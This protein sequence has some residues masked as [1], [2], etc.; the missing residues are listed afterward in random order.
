VVA[1]RY[2]DRIERV[3]EEAQREMAADSSR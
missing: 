1:E 2:A 3:Y